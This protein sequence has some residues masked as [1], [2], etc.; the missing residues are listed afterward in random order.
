V[1][2][3]PG[4]SVTNWVTINPQKA[5]LVHYNAYG[6][7]ADALGSLNLSHQRRR[8][9]GER[10]ISSRSPAT[11]RLTGEEGEEDRLV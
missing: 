3:A 4:A 8:P 6:E 2:L 10:T 9:G 11:C 5:G 7:Y 1:T